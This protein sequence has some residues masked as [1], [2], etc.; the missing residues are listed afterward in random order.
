MHNQKDDK[1]HKGSAMYLKH[2]VSGDLVEV[3]DMRS[4]INPN[5]TK[6]AGRFH[7][8]EE[9][10]DPANF[11]KSELIFP[12]GESLPRCWIDAAYR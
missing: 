8:G 11:N 10:Q 12:S 4:L 3:L 6:V 5:Q 9:L 1:P 2:T 7:A